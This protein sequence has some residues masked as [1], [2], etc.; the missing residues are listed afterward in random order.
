MSRRVSLP[1]VVRLLADQLKLSTSDDARAMAVALAVDMA[2]DQ[3]PQHSFNYDNKSYMGKAR[4]FVF[5]MKRNEVRPRHALRFVASA[6]LFSSPISSPLSNTNTFSPSLRK[7]LRADLLSGALTPAL[8]VTLT[9]ADLAA[10]DVRKARQVMAAA[11]MES[12]RTDWVEEHREKIQESIGLDPT[13][14]W[15]YDEDDESVDS[16]G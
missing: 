12:R 14:V 3:L 15:Q 7:S 9:P 4:S 5:N 1:Q 16:I 10:D 11:D 13:N 6:S 8:L 2:I